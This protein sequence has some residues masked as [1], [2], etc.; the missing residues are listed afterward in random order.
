VDAPDCAAGS[1]FRVCEETTGRIVFECG[2]LYEAMTWMRW[3]PLSGPHTLLAP[4]GRILV[5]KDS[6]DAAH[7]AVSR[8]DR[9]ND[10]LT[11]YKRGQKPARLE[12]TKATDDDALTLEDYAR[13]AG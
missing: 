1:G 3:H 13:Q 12:E 2:D 9:A 4:D 8:A 10:K 7:K 5:V 6:W 11:G